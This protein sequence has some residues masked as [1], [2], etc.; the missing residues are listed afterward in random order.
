MDS[1]LIYSRELIENFN[2]EVFNDRPSFTFSEL[3]QVHGT[4]IIKP[5]KSTD[6]KA[7]GFIIEK[8][9]MKNH[10]LAIKTAD[11]NPIVLVGKNEVAFL[12]AGH[13]GIQKKIATSNII[14]DIS[15][16]FCFVGPSIKRCCFE[17]QADFLK[18][19]PNSNS[20]FKRKNKLFFDLQIEL[21]SDLRQLFSQIEIINSNICTMCSRDPIFNSYRKNKTVKRNYNILRIK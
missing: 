7:D 9:K 19:F 16:Y 11:C 8:S 1:S 13:A 21:N 4:T 10:V 2:F 18:G 12:H 15:P 20:T 6:D 14:Q 17:V 5:E 3:H